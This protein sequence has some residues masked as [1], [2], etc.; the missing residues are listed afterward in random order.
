MTLRVQNTIL[1]S[2]KPHGTTP[3]CDTLS[4]ELVKTRSIVVDEVKVTVV[5]DSI[6]CLKEYIFINLKSD[7][8]SELLFFSQDTLVLKSP[9]I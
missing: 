4:I 5:Y 2:L 8:T 7:F 1:W 9:N 3:D 6:S